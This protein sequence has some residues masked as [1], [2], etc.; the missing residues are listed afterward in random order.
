MLNNFTLLRHF[1]MTVRSLFVMPKNFSP[2]GINKV[3]LMQPTV[4]AAYLLQQ[5]SGTFSTKTTIRSA[6]NRIRQQASIRSRK[7][8]QTI[9]FWIKTKP[10]PVC[11]LSTRSNSNNTSVNP[12]V[13]M[14]LGIIVQ[15]CE[16]LSD[17]VHG[18]HQVLFSWTQGWRSSRNWRKISV[19]LFFFSF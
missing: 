4:W 2:E 15:K 8:W 11:V 12:N 18:L 13:N 6:G 3:I 7:P 14:L 10:S 1:L 16:W 5:G 9:D 17:V 19:F